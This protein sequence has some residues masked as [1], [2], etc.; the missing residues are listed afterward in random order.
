[1]NDFTKYREKNL[2]ETKQ[3]IKQSVTD[4]LLIIQSIRHIQ[5]LSKII[6][7]LVKDLIEWYSYYNPESCKKQNDQD[8]YI[9]VNDIINNNIKKIKDSMGADLSEDH[10]K[11]MINLAKEIGRLFDFK[12][13]QEKYLEKMMINNCPNITK[14]VSASIGARLIEHA[15][16]LK[17]LALMPSST[18]QLLGAEEA[19]FRHIKT[20][21]KCPRHGLIVNHPLISTA[22][23]KEHGKRARLIANKISIASRVDYCKGK[24]VGDKLLKEIEEKIGLMKK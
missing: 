8:H 20:K 13:D 3:K 11:P 7:T 17:K 19:L 5:D 10:L 24:F 15:G 21:S 14:I 2:I 6:N 23:Q 16:S 1:M 9:L 4:D 18:V 22:P 12:K